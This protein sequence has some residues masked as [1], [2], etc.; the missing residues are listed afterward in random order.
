MAGAGPS[1]TASSASRTC[2]AERSASECTATAFTP[3]R[4]QAAMTAQAAGPRPATSTLSIPSCATA[5][6]SCDPPTGAATLCAEPDRPVRGLPGQLGGPGDAAHATCAVSP[7]REDQGSQ[8]RP[9]APRE[10][11]SDVQAWTQA[12]LPQEEQANH[13]KRPNA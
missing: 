4:V 2:R 9:T 13:G 11:G 6:S 1:S 12:S 7:A 8:H 5:V 10:E 3:S